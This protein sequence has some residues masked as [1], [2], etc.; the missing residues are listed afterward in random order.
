MKKINYLLILLIS[1]ISLSVFAEEVPEIVRRDINTMKWYWTPF[2]Q[3]K[4]FLEAVDFTKQQKT[5]D[6]KIYLPFGEMNRSSSKWISG[7]NWLRIDCERMTVENLGNYINFD[8]AVK[9]RNNA[10]EKYFGEFKPEID[11]AIVN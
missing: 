3:S 2:A 1:I 5:S 6:G 8:E 7:T 10:E 9:A 4:G 11:F